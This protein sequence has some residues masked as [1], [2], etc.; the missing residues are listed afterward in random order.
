MTSALDQTSSAASKLL[1]D[2]GK[3]WLWIE[4]ASRVPSPARDLQSQRRFQPR[5]GFAH[6]GRHR[7]FARRATTGTLKM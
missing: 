7:A 1:P 3:F 4:L 2:L 6:G 5:P